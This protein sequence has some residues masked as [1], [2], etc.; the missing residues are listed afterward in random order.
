MLFLDIDGTF[1]PPQMGEEQQEVARV[2]G[3]EWIERRCGWYIEAASYLVDFL[4]ET[5]IPVTML[6]TWGES[7]ALI[8]KNFEFEAGNLVMDQEPGGIEG[9]FEAVKGYHRVH[10]GEKIVW[11]DD[12]IEDE[13]VEECERL[14]ITTIVPDKD[15]GLTQEDV[16]KIKSVLL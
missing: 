5:D 15:R 10:P 9:K 4:R 14:G 8:P 7:A 2:E 6:S 13:M 16:E 1:S 11:A 3:F 12:M